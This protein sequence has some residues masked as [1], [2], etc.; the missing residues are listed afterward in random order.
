[1]QKLFSIVFLIFVASCD[2]FSQQYLWPTDASHWM[3]S[4]FAETRPRR[5][6]AA[7]DIKT[8]N[9]T[10]YKV[11]AVRDGY[12]QRI[13]VSPFGY[14][15][16]IYHKLDTGEIAI[17][18]HLSGFNEK[19]EEYVVR[20]Q[21][22][23]GR[24]RLDRYLSPHDFP[25]KKGEILGYTGETGI[26]VPHLH[27]EMR[28]AQNRPFNPLQKGFDVKD[29]VAPR[30]TGLAVIPLTYGARV[31]GDF[32]PRMYSLRKQGGNAY[33]IEE[34]FSI[35]GEVGLAVKCYDKTDEGS[36]RFHVYEIHLYIDGQPH[37]SI[38]YDKF[39]YGHN[40]LVQLERDFRFERQGYGRYIHLYQDEQN[41]LKF[42]RSYSDAKGRLS[43]ISRI[44]SEQLAKPSAGSRFL[45]AGRHTF[46][47]ELKDYFCNM[48]TVSGGFVA[49]SRFKIRPEIT[50][51]DS[52]QL[53]G[54][55]IPQDITAVDLTIWER[56]PG[57]AKDW[58]VKHAFVTNGSNGGHRFFD[59]L[60]V[61]LS[62]A[63][64]PIAGKSFRFVVED[65]DGAPSWP[66]FFSTPHNG[67]RH[68]V[69]I[70]LQPEFY[71]DYLRV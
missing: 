11:F 65:K 51:I 58:V 8:W 24:Y 9:R 57:N 12:I 18:A 5:M 46:R 15:K 52:I 68:A 6:H 10:G 33:R 63:G 34:T 21:E 26:G 56:A 50:D 53:H 1:M 27:F 13:R 48:S 38:K 55:Q 28:D 67:V 4:S 29:K 71:D 47:I 44:T 36:N 40:R 42:Y 61:T 59:Y 43:S 70:D 16:A 2:L 25:V 19:L 23:D 64:Q 41:Q 22:K 31:N 14:G 17:Y 7:I 37:F 66:A 54:V 60:P 69:R 62:K 39:S 35:E 3:T 49:G 45:A 32:R 20:E 30:P